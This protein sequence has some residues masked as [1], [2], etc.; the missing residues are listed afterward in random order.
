M[1]WLKHLTQAHNDEAMSELLDEFGAEGYGVWWIILEKIAAQMDKK[2]RCFV[3]YP[4]KK[5]AKSCQVS[6]KKFQKIVSFLSELEKLLAKTC[7]KNS[8]FLIIECSNLLKF[9]DE[10]SKKSGQTPDKL[11]KKTTKCREQDTDTD[12]DTDTE[13]KKKVKKK[14]LEGSDELRLAEFLYHNILKFKSDFKQP[15]LQKWASDAKKMLEIDNRDLEKVKKLIEWVCKDDFER[16]NVLSIA[17]LRKRFD[18]LEIKMNTKKPTGQLAKKEEKSI[19]EILE[20][21][22]NEDGSINLF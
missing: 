12:T 22:L 11:Q 19:R 18:P 14:Y 10:Y 6:V 3:R 7:E 5:W 1:R 21:N 4:L 8:S 13:L 15:N 2:Q 17:K 9:R 20:E 16:S